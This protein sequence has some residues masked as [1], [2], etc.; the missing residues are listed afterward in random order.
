MPID[1]SARP[2]RG[3]I[4]TGGTGALGR[5]L[6]RVLLAAG[7]AGRG[8]VPRRADEWRALQEEAGA[9]A[10][11][12][13]DDG[14]PRPTRR[15]PGR[16]S[17]RPR[18]RLGVLDGVALVAGGWAGRHELRRGARRRVGPRCCGPTS[19]P[20]PT[21]A[22]RRSPTC[23]KHG[24]SVVAVGSRAAETGGA[25][26]G[27]LRRLEGGGPRPRPRA[28]ARE[29]R[30]AASAS[31]PSC[32][33]TIDTPA[34]R[35]AMPGAD[36]SKWTSPD[37]I[38]RVMA[39][40]LSPE[41][42]PTTGALVPVDAPGLSSLSAT[43]SGRSAS[44]A[45]RRRRPSPRGRGRRGGAR[46]R[47]DGGSGRAPSGRT[48]GA[49]GAEERPGLAALARGQVAGEG[50]RRLAGGGRRAARRSARRS[51][52]RPAAAEGA[53]IGANV[54]SPAPLG[55]RAGDVVRWAPWRSTPPR[56]ASG[57]TSRPRS[58]SSPPP[59]SSPSR[60]RSS[61]APPSARSSR[62]ATC[63]RRPRAP[64]LPTRRPASW[65]PCSTPGSRSPRASSSRCTSTHRRPLLAAFLDALGLPHED[66][67]LKEEA[68]AAAPVTVE[69]AKAAI[70]GPRV[71]PAGEVRTYLNTLWLQDPERWAAL[72]AAVEE[73]PRVKI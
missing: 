16:S 66:G 65:P 6:V 62:P 41:S 9:G 25:R 44:P 13:G 59:P 64:S 21:S 33:G 39:F 71:L 15:A 3:V 35:R 36:R 48:G 52:I 27:R 5:A 70:G 61:P 49:L 22:A 54:S 1:V 26:D 23:A 69:K 28:R 60:R 57:S 17:T 32:P 20:S 47:S 18:R 24:G 31:T 68:D 8:A 7:R 67:V 58:A 40:L 4:V 73:A 30:T 53:P 46:G 63:G 11:L 45:T 50:L 10:A 19:T 14:R 55:G 12:F 51:G 37:A 42:A 38:A 2:A 34:N 72:E 43:G 56:P 29:R